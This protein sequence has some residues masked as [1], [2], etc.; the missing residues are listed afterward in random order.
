MTKVACHKFIWR[1]TRHT[2]ILHS[3]GIFNHM[4]TVYIFNL[5]RYYFS[6]LAIYKV[7]SPSYDTNFSMKFP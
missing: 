2:F 5:I 7:K 3:L 1:W 6:Q 4:S